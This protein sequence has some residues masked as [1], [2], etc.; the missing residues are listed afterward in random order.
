SRANTWWRCQA[1][2]WH[3]CVSCCQRRAWY[4]SKSAFISAWPAKW[5]SLRLTIMNRN[6]TYTDLKGRVIVLADLDAEEREL[7]DE[8]KSYAAAHPDWN[9]FGNHWMPKV[10]AFYKARG[11]TR[12]EIIASDVWRIAQ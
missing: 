8:L 12:R 9:E 6:K 11:L 4:S 3:G 1:R 5:S 2:I 10:H 7:V